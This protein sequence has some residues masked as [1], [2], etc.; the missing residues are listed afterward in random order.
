VIKLEGRYSGQISRNKRH[1][2]G[3]LVDVKGHQYEGEWKDDKPHG[4]GYKVKC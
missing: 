1:G 3:K 2:K 4:W